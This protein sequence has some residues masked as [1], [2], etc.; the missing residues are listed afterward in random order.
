MPRIPFIGPSYTSQSPDADCS[1]TVNWY[2]EDMEVMNG[3]TTQTLYPTPGATL[4]VSL[5]QLVV[6]GLFT[7][8]GRCFAVAGTGYYE[9][10][11][12]GV[13]TLRGTVTIGS[14]PAFMCTNGDAGG[15]VFIVT[16]GNAFCHTLATNAFAQVITGTADVG[17][18]VDGYFL[19]LDAATSTL[20]YSALNDGTSWPA[21]NI[22]QRSTAA[23][24]WV[25]MVV[26]DR[27][28]HLYGATTSES[29]YNSGDALTPFVPVQGSLI[30][31]GI[32][33][34][35]SSVALVD[36]TRIWLTANTDGTGVV[37][38][39]LGFLPQRI[40]THAI[41]HAIQNY[42]ITSDATAWS[43]QEEG[44]TFYVLGFPTARATWV[45]DTTTGLW[46]E[47]GWWDSALM[48]YETVRGRCHTYCFGKHLIGDRVGAGVYWQRVS[49]YQDVGGTDLRRMRQGPHLTNDDEW[50]Y[51]PEVR[52]ILETGVATPSVP[53]PQVMLQWSDDGGHTWS[54]EHWASA[55]LVGHYGQHA[56]WHRCGRSR[57]RVFRVVTSDA[58]PFRL[59]DM[60]VGT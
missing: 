12:L 26:S 50:I 32:A 21:L 30:Q 46:H 59:L 35:Y 53:D 3:K 16:E 37:K 43:Y 20:Y 8:R 52:L 24:P 5:P 10:D 23:D 31:D 47:R 27:K 44:H 25:S 41:E 33:A 45:F 15:Q 34:P 56:V 54:N 19:A 38:R 36:N 17:G 42:E 13:V 11:T 55:G 51:Y 48:R 9:I 18:F 2:P 6:R 58:V 60:Q 28:V 7:H 49:T 14:N 40:S 57:D 29:W 39:A 22:V 4:F 1:R